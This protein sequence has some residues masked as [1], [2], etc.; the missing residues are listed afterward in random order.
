MPLLGISLDEVATLQAYRAK[1]G[2]PFPLLCDSA[3][4]AGA[5]FRV[6]YR[7]GLGKW[8][9]DLFQTASFVVD[10][11]G[12]VAGVWAKGGHQA[13]LLQAAVALDRMS[14]RG[15]THPR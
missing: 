3:K 12:V 4:V 10:A 2:M 8:A 11:S 15:S 14:E 5:A 13:E 6:V 7:F 9:V 1:A